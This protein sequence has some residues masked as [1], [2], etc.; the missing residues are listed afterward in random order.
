MSGFSVFAVVIAAVGLF[1]GLSYAVAQRSRE[2]GVRTA[3]GAR[4]GDI[5]RLVLRQTVVILAAGLTAGVWMAFAASQYLATVLYGVTPHD[6]VSFVVVPVG[7]ALVA[8]IACVVPARR[9]ARVDPLTA[10][11]CG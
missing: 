7:V 11:R 2:I 5:T 1:G 8:A 6:L 3:L 10:L 9:A 4:P